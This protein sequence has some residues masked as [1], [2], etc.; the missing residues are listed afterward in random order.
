MLASSASSNELSGS[1]CSYG[2][3]YGRFTIAF[4]T[5]KPQNDS[6]E[7]SPAPATAFIQAWWLRNHCRHKL[8]GTILPNV[9]HRL[10]PKRRNGDRIVSQERDLFGSFSCFP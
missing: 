2:L 1:S 9:G 7:R 8:H 10:A 6:N 3:N 5:V 4:Q